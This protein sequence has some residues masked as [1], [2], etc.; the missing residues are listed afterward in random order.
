MP[1]SF[2][3]DVMRALR[4]EIVAAQ[5]RDAW[6]PFRPGAT[7]IPPP[8]AGDEKRSACPTCGAA[9]KTKYVEGAV[10]AWG[11]KFRDHAKTPFVPVPRR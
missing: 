8:A 11:C 10:Y 6:R 9:R 3:R 1:F 7:E 5:A 2:E 4:P